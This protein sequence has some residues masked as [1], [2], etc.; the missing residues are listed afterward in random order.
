MAEQPIQPTSRPDGRAS[1]GIL[2]IVLLA[3]LAA[4]VGWWGYWLARGQLPPAPIKAMLGLPA[5]S[6]GCTRSLMA[7][8]RGD[9]RESLRWNPFA[10]PML[11]MLVGSLAWVIVRALRRRRVVLPERLATAWLILLPVAWAVKLF[12]DPAYW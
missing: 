2:S 11:L 8:A 4:Y 10:V 12:G 3:G 6:T 1:R 5:P 9:W 7:L